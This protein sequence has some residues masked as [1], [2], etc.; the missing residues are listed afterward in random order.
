[1]YPPSPILHPLTC[2]CCC[3]LWLALLVC[4][5]SHPSPCLGNALVSLALRIRNCGL[6]GALCGCCVAV[7]GRRMKSIA[8]T[9]P[10]PA[11]TSP[12]RPTTA[13]ASSGSGSNQPPLLTPVQPSGGAFFTGGTSPAA[14]AAARSGSGTSLTG[15]LGASSASA[16]LGVT[17]GSG[18][19]SRGTSTGPVART[20][21]GTPGA[22]VLSPV[23]VRQ[24]ATIAV[25]P[26]PIHCSVSHACVQCR[27]A[28]KSGMVAGLVW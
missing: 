1:M 6:M 10:P 21:P 7:T 14:A 8:A 13:G 4:L 2:G 19:G 3:H 18:G 28:G 23:K 16:A 5:S 26:V 9:L 24:E 27:C 22:P 20:S 17:G 12:A 11:Y 15:L 25:S